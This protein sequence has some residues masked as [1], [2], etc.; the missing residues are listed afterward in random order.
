MKKL[1]I[2]LVGTLISLQPPLHA[3]DSLNIPAK[4]RYL[5]VVSKKNRQVTHKLHHANVEK[6]NRYIDRLE[7]MEKTVALLHPQTAVHVFPPLINHAKTFRDQLSTATQLPA[8]YFGYLDTLQGTIKYIVQ[9]TN[10]TSQSYTQAKAAI[11]SMQR[12]VSVTEQTTA[13]IEAGNRELAAVL[14]PLGS[15][16]KELSLLQIDLG[17]YLRQIETYKTLLAD[18]KKIEQKVITLLQHNKLFQSFMSHN[19][20]YAGLLGL[21]QNYNVTRTL[22]DLQTRTIVDP[23]LQTRIGTDPSLAGSRMDMA[24]SQFEDYKSRYA[25]RQ[26]ADKAASDNDHQMKQMNRHNRLQTGANISFQKAN[27]YF[28]AT[29]EIT[30]QLGYRFHKKG[31]TG[32]AINY[33]LGMGN[34]WEYITISHQG[35]GIRSFLDWQIKGNIYVTG[36]AGINRLSPFHRLRE[37]YDW[38]G[39]QLSALA[40]VKKKV[41]LKGNKSAVTSIEYDFLAARTLSRPLRICFGY[42]FR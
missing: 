13:I 37:L 8:R 19:S 38:K 30:A 2:L 4:E 14:Q 5:R 25:E 21:P 33:L 18:P 20:L 35:I 40:G 32:I 9:Q 17:N 34:G 29:A 22:E 27:M 41:Q 1:Y 26:H 15:F 39:N 16:A 12:E 23:L 11:T 31:V 28:P 10:S 6:L 36:G 3:Q 7:K 42:N 24:R